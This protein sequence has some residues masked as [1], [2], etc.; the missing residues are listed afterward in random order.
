M[1]NKDHVEV[2]GSE[3]LDDIKDTVEEHIGGETGIIRVF[4]SRLVAMRD[5]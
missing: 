1:G 5:D 2:P 3:E 4:S